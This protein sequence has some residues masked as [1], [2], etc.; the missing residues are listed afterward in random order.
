MKVPFK[1]RAKDAQDL[2]QLYLRSERELDRF[3]KND[4]TFGILVDR[5]ELGN[6]E[7]LPLSK[8]LQLE[9]RA[10]IQVYYA[11]ECQRIEHDLEGKI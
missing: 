2:I 1:L 3:S 5:P 9:I 11:N 8:E 7:F 4:F 10:A 6:E